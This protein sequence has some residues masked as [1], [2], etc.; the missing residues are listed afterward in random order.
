MAREMRICRRPAPPAG[1]S[2]YLRCLL[3]SLVISN[4]ETWD[5]PPNTGLS[6]SSALMLRRFFLSC[7]LWRLMY[8]QIFLVTSVRGIAPLPIT[9]PSA[10]LGFIGFMNAAF[11]LRF[12]PDFFAFFFAICDSPLIGTVLGIPGIPAAVVGAAVP[13]QCRIQR[14][15]SITT[16][17]FFDYFHSASS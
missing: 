12:L 7:R 9:A 2:D 15:M 10:A 8:C 11:G 13:E 6:L 5:L 14:S 16:S 1:C 3:T 4:I 17:G